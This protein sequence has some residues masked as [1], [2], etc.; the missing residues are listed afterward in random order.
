[1]KYRIIK[2]CGESSVVP[3]FSKIANTP[4]YVFAPDSNFDKV[5]LFDSVGNVVNLNSWLEC[6]YYVN[7]GWTNNVSDFY[8]GEKTV[9]IFTSIAFLTH[10]LYIKYFKKINFSKY[11]EF[12]EE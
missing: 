5:T 3:D 8:N 11:I 10:I 4:N 6:A 12:N 1:M 2:I 9:F 7:G